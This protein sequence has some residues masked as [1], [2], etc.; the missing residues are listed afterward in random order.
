MFGPT[1]IKVRALTGAPILIAETGASLAA[2]QSVKVTDLFAGIQAYG[3]LGFVWFDVN[4]T[5]QGLDWRLSSPAALAYRHDAKAFMRPP[6]TP[7]S[8]Q[9]PSSSG[10]SP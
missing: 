6:A 3:L 8:T 10:T 4:D 5:A 7:V 2:D 9:H 1:I